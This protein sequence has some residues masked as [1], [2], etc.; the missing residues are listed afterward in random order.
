MPIC[1]C[2]RHGYRR[3][4]P[5]FAREKNELLRTAIDT[6]FLKKELST[7]LSTVP[8]HHPFSW[9]SL[10]REGLILASI[11]G[12]RNVSACFLCAA[13]GHPPLTAVPYHISWNMSGA[14]SKTFSQ[15]FEVSLFLIPEQQ[16]FKFCYT[17]PNDNLCNQTSSPSQDLIA[18]EG[19]LSVC[20]LFVCLFVLGFGGLF[21]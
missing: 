15:I 20:F 21:V 17:S 1:F 8:M 12:L 19:F 14:S 5:S 7:Q 16:Q 10:L 2:G 3:F 6:E 13:L 18:S 4:C 9:F 11:T